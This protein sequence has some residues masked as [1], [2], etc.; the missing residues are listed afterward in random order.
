MRTSTGSTKKTSKTNNNLLVLRDLI[1]NKVPGL[2]NLVQVAVHFRPPPKV[3]GP[4][5]ADVWFKGLTIYH[6]MV[7]LFKVLC[8]L[9]NGLEELSLH[10]LRIQAK[11]PTVGEVWNPASPEHTW[12]ILEMMKAKSLTLAYVGPAVWPPTDEPQWRDFVPPNFWILPAMSTL[13]HLSLTCW[14]FYM[15]EWTR[16]GNYVSRDQNLLPNLES[17]ELGGCTFISDLELNWILAHKNTLRSLKLD[18]CAMIYYLQM[19][20][21]NDFA[22]L[23]RATRAETKGNVRLQFFHSRWQ[24]WFHK[25][26][27]GLPHLNDFQFGNSWIR[28]P[29]EEGPPAA[30]FQSERVKGPR[31][32]QKPKFLLGLFPDRYLEIKQNLI[33]APRIVDPVSST[34]KKRP[35]CD[36]VDVVALRLL[37][38]HTK[39]LGVEENATSDHAGYVEDLLGHVKPREQA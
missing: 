13:R 17:L 2:T 28:A 24:E 8:M 7:D 16:F 4:Y 14:E 5:E 11:V 23:S 6:M 31:F 34:Y 22:N 19:D 25:F 1:E 35:T 27:A 39:Q 10:C 26:R 20:L 21:D 32:E 3:L 18:D 38:K 36:K 29:G 37:P 30:F 15:V 33:I 9:Q 12:W